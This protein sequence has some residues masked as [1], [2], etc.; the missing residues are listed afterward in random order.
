[1]ET[2]AGDSA[3]GEKTSETSTSLDA[4]YLKDFD[5]SMTHKRWLPGDL[6]DKSGI[7]PT[8]SPVSPKKSYSMDELMDA[9]AAMYS[10]DPIPDPSSS[11]TPP[12]T[13][14]GSDEAKWLGEIYDA[15]RRGRARNY[16][17]AAPLKIHPLVMNDY[18]STDSYSAVDYP[19]LAVW[20]ALPLN[21]VIEAIY[22]RMP[23]R[24][25]D[26]MS[27]TS[28]NSEIEVVKYAFEQFRALRYRSHRN[29]LTIW[30]FHQKRAS[31]GE[32]FEWGDWSVSTDM[33]MFLTF[34]T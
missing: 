34:S 30:C 23:M 17:I 15:A 31:E 11:T 3:G 27:H 33:K 7:Y 4:D 26:R 25:I 18:Y 21:D 19:S 28:F 2:P 1:M 24:E 13:H 9:R 6:I 29:W 5:L 10:S 8:A 20:V 12:P 22:E 14:Y 32:R 16:S